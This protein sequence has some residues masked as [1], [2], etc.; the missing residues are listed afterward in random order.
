MKTA[1]TRLFIFINANITLYKTSLQKPINLILP[2]NLY[3]NSISKYTEKYVRQ[4]KR[5]KKR[6]KEY[7]RDL[8]Y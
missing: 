3:I 4:N 6:I 2:I 1:Y 5:E 7:K 8:I